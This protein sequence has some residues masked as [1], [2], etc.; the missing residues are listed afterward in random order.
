MRLTCTNRDLA[1][2]RCL[3]RPSTL[4]SVIVSSRGVSGHATTVEQPPVHRVSR[5]DIASA[6]AAHIMFVGH[7]AA[8]FILPVIGLSGSFAALLLCCQLSDVLFFSFVLTGV[9]HMR[10]V[11]GFTAS[12]DLDLF[13]MPYTHSLVGAFVLALVVFVLT[14]KVSY[15]IATLSHW[16]G[17]VVFHVADLTLAGGESKFGFGLWQHKWVAFGAET[18]FFVLAAAA[19]ARSASR[20]ERRALSA[21]FWVCVVLHTVNWVQPLPVVSV[22]E[23]SVQALIAYFA[24]PLVAYWLSRPQKNQ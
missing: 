18:V 9:E 2:L 1:G 8:A 16:F 7:L 11:P 10:I 3:T 21:V 22:R 12:N 14:R 6:F 23:L 4:L 15:A 20:D 24:V 13:H 17:D 5:C 19:F